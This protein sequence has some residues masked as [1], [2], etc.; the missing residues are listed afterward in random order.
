MMWSTVAPPPCVASVVFVM[1]G[2]PHAHIA[3]THVQ[4]VSVF[5]ILEWPVRGFLLKC[6]DGARDAKA[7]A[8]VAGTLA[9]VLIADNI[10]HNL[11]V[12][13]LGESV[14]LFP[15]RPQEPSGDGGALL[16]GLV[17]TCTGAGGM[18]WW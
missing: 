17:V 15:R 8:D 5:E 2:A 16:D 12:G 9:C 6:K 1:Q 4:H 14:Y 13:S 3:A 18:C 10:G 7:L 11:L